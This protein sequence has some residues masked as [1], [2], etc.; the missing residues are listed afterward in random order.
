[1]EAI[2][3]FPAAGDGVRDLRDRCA[4]AVVALAA[5]YA[6]RFNRRMVGDP[7]FPYKDVC[8]VVGDRTG[9][10]RADPTVAGRLTDERTA[11]LVPAAVPNL[12]TA[13]RLGLIDRVARFIADGA[14]VAERDLFG[15]DALKW[16]VVRDNRPVLDL[17]IAAGGKPDFCGALA[18]AVTYKRHSLVAELAGRCELHSRRLDLLTAAVKDG[19]TQVV[20]ALVETEPAV[21][22]TGSNKVEGA[23]SAAVQIDRGDLVGLI[24][25]R[26]SVEPENAGDWWNGLRQR[27]LTRAI[28]ARKL[29]VAEVLLERGTEPDPQELHRAVQRK[30]AK[31]V[32][33]LAQH[34]TDL[35][36]KGKEMP[37]VA[38]PPG[39]DGLL[40]PLGRRLPP[41]SVPGDE[42]ARRYADP[43]IFLALEPLLDVKMVALLL[44]L[45][46]NPNVRDTSGR[47]PLM[48]AIAHSRIYGRKNGVGWIEPYVPRHLIEGQE[49]WAHLGVEPVRAL[50]AKGADVG[51]TDGEGLTALHHAARSDYNAE[52]AAILLRHGA[53]ANARDAAGRTPLDH[54]VAAKLV[55]MPE[56]LAAAAAGR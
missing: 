42:I 37:K 36:R 5:D 43:P 17:L 50:L 20:R 1:M 18:A 30:A 3:V 35:D 48:V 29:T 26:A 40:D 54:A 33:L 22:L 56:V 51:L 45:G 28:A 10:G 4:S 14:D 16:A 52:I 46:A 13:A 12:P 27:L 49:D 11:D 19:S 38:A 9:E 23:L 32:R 7:G 47:T 24:L 6:S 44:D 2:A 39:R 31:I 55:R 15:F 21:V 34:G 25:D 8:V 53:D 41:P